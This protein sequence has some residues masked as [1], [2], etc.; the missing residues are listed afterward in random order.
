MNTFEFVGLI[1]DEINKDDKLLETIVV[2]VRN[3][4]E[5]W[6]VRERGFCYQRII[7]DSRLKRDVSISWKILFRNLSQGK[8]PTNAVGILDGLVHLFKLWLS[9]WKKSKHAEKDYQTKTFS[10][11][12][13]K[14]IPVA[15]YLCWFWSENC[16]N[17]FLIIFFFFFNHLST[18]N[19]RFIHKWTAN[20]TM[21]EFRAVENSKLLIVHECLTVVWLKLK[22]TT[23][24][25]H[26]YFPLKTELFENALQSGWIRRRQF[27][28]L[29]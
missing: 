6:R 9:S 23:S 8:K 20:A 27:C 19:C 15:R 28:V 2:Y 7:K 17:D 21:D 18:V 24:Q 16:L 26:C 25:E 1:V 5:G 29:G 3:D 12:I 22:K 14:K 10:S 4:C 13:Y 11:R